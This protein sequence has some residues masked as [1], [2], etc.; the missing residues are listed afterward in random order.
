MGRC[1]RAAWTTWTGEATSASPRPRSRPSASRRSSR[2]L[3]AAAA[4]RPQAEDECRAL[5]LEN[6]ALRCRIRELERAN[7][8][9]LALAGQ[10]PEPKQDA[11]ARE[12][13]EAAAVADGCR[14]CPNCG[15]GVPAA[16]YDAHV[17]HCERNFYRCAACGDIVPA[18]E[19]GEHLARWTDLAWALRAAREGDLPVL[20]SI[21]AH[22]ARLESVTCQESG[23]TLLHVAAQRG[24][25]ELLA[26]LLSRGT[27]AASWLSAASKSGQAALHLAVSGGHEPVAALL[28]ESRA[29]VNQRNSAGDTPLLV[30]C[31][32]GAASL[33]RRLVD[34]DADLDARTALGDSALQ[35]AQAKGHME[36]GL[37]LSVRRFHGSDHG[38]SLEH[39]SMPPLRPG[40]R[41]ADPELTKTIGG[42]APPTAGP[43]RRP[44]TPLSMR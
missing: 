20:R 43:C 32:S 26:L 2:C 31:R 4:Q 1:L 36:C 13:A 39:D 19:K 22:G 21:R 5:R 18:R 10:G 34:A 25:P 12:A 11:A 24:C 35:V 9:L 7:E 41:S 15:R 17:M 3:V 30:A 16:N 44:P 40:A 27:P 33:V 42:S 29:E 37:A 28:L 23:E 8:E 6:E 14:V 38:S